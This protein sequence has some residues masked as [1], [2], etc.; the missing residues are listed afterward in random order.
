MDP[1]R[2]PTA[3][4]NSNTIHPYLDSV[5]RRPLLLPLLLVV[6]DSAANKVVRAVSPTRSECGFDVVVVVVSDWLVVVVL[7]CRCTLMAQMVCVCVLLV[8]FLLGG[9]VVCLLLY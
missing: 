4:T 8:A 1:M 5:V 3:V 7:D 6:G 2:K 9:L